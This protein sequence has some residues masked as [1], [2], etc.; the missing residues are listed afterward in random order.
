[1]ILTEEQ[2]A[3][4][5]EAANICHEVTAFDVAAVLQ[6]MIDSGDHVPDATKLMGFDLERAR[7]LRDFLQNDCAEVGDVWAEMIAEIERLRSAALRGNQLISELMA[8]CNSLRARAW[9]A[10]ARIK[11]L[12]EALV[13]ERAKSL[14]IH[15]DTWGTASRDSYR[16]EARQQL[17]EEGKIANGDHINDTIKLIGADAEA[18]KCQ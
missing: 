16:L 8:N 14:V 1:M 12:E 4:I 18:K 13:E 6:A 7:G 17:Q 3:A 9:K 11:E 5:E 15:P 2:R 10:E